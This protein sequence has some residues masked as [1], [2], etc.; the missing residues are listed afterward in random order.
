MMPS[1]MPRAAGDLCEGIGLDREAST[2][3]HAV[4]AHKLVELIATQAPSHPLSLA[5]S[6]PLPRSLPLPPLSPCHPSRS[7]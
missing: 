6:P 3:P 4:E 2:K 1:W 5:L 7:P